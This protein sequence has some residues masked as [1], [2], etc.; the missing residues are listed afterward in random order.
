[1]TIGMV[2]E[3]K[4]VENLN[5]INIFYL[6]FFLKILFVYFRQSGREGER[7]GER[8]QCVVASHAP[9]TGDLAATQACALTGNQ[10]GE[11]LVCRLV[12]SPLSHTSQ[13]RR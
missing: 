13:G 2:E 6:N 10:T 9:S 4:S 5:S 8:H 1:M 12:L 3:I 7:E 11:P